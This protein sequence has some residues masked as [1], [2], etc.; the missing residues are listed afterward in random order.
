MNVN[1]AFA[2]KK[3]NIQHKMSNT[4]TFRWFQQLD[5]IVFSL[6]FLY[7]IEMRYIVGWTK[8]K[9]LCQFSM[10]NGFDVVLLR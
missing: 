10:Q 9:L 3:Q 8:V 4:K 6:R 2:D 7:L 5:R 1:L